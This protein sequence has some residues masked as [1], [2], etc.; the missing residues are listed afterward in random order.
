MNRRHGESAF[1]AVFVEA[2]RQ[3]EEALGDARRAWIERHAG[4]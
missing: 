3:S 4:T 2:R 1:E